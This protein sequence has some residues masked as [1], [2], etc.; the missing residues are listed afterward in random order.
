[1]AG[2]AITDL[3]IGVSNDAV[4][5]LGAAMGSHTA[6]FRTILIIASLGVLI[7]ATFSNGMM[8]VARKGVLFPQMFLFEEL[9]VIFI[10]VMITD[11]IMMDTFNSL[12]LPT[13][14]TVS[15]VFELLGAAVAVSLI[16]VYHS[17]PDGG[18]FQSL[19]ANIAEIDAYIN[20]NKAAQM[21]TGI[22]AVVII[23]FFVGAMVQWVAR[24]I[25]TFRYERKLK[26]YGGIV[27]GIAFT[28]MTFFMLLKGAKGTT[29]ISPE[30]K[31]WVAENTYLLMGVTFVITFIISQVV[32]SVFKKNILK[33]IVLAGTF[34]LAMA[35]AGND[36]VNFIGVPLAAWSSYEAWV[37][38]GQPIESLHMSAL[39]EPAH[40]PILILASAG[41]IMVITL[42]TSKRAKKV[43]KTSIDLSKYES[44]DENHRPNIVSR[45]LVRGAVAIGKFTSRIMPD[46]MTRQVELR[47]ARP[48]VA[49]PQGKEYEAPA[50]DMVRASVNVIVPA[51]L[52]S[53]G[54]SSTLPLSTTYVTFMVA[55][56]SSLADKAWGRESAVYRVAGVLKVILGWFATAFF[57]FIAAGTFATFVYHYFMLAIIPLLILGVVIMTISRMRKRS[58]RREERRQKLL[59]TTQHGMSISEVIEDSAERVS[60]SFTHATDIYSSVAIGLNSQDRRSLKHAC[61]MA[62]ELKEDIRDL[63]NS[64]FHMVKSIDDRGLEASRFYILIL[65]YLKDINRAL[66]N[67]SEASLEHVENNHKE[68]KET[69]KEA[70]LHMSGELCSIFDDIKRCFLTR[71]FSGVK[72]ILARKKEL[73]KFLNALIERQ[74]SK[75]R[76]E[77]MDLSPKNTNLYLSI[78]LETKDL[79]SASTHLAELGLQFYVDKKATSKD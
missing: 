9:I 30:T 24:F 10:S 62:A 12:G 26:Y 25:F 66:T 4:N 64:V 44:T 8:E 51:I 20:Q 36:L 29:L 6:S 34:S 43:L 35:F 5:F 71:D 37:A 67:I 72:S 23:A 1:M 69:R 65:D 13:S 42:Y 7:G 19:V 47:F 28:A 55:M 60:E 33:V 22:F 2:L 57:A 3:T 46:F 18:S 74:I 17:L 63:Q 53:W 11:V 76:D 48:A 14:T 56:G 39:L 32:V 52:I 79:L 31:V 73:K 58:T 77:S 68:F 15:L 50:F 49:L 16:K 54:T 45:S 40:T 75:I 38:A 70:L 61:S 27:G 59:R 78:I 41:M 21:V